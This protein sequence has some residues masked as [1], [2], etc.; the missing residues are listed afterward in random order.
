MSSVS[1][2][3]VSALPA[4]GRLMATLLA[5]QVCGSTG[6]SISLA[7]G[8]IVAA[9]LTGSNTWSGLPVSV[10]ALGA[11][12]AS[13]PLARAM[14]RF[15]RRP[16]LVVGYGLGVLGSGLGMLGVMTR[17]FPLLLVGMLLFGIGQTSN[18]L[19][20][21][22]AADVST[23]AQRGRAIGLI[24]WGSTLGS[25]VGP[26][27]LGPAAWSAGPLGLPVVGSPFLIGLAGFGLAALLVEALLRPDPLTVAAQLE[28]PAKADR[29][30]EPARPLRTI[31]RQPSVRLA[32]GAL[33]TSQLVMIGT[34]STSPVYLHD[35]GHHVD[36]IGLAVSLHLAG[37]YAASPL[38]GWLCDRFGRI[39][40]ITAGGLVLIGAVAL[41]A[42]APGSDSTVVSLALFLNGVGWNFGFVAG[43]ALLT[44]SL[45]PAERTSMQGLAD[46]VMGLMGAIGSAIGGVILQLW[47][48]PILNIVGAALILGPLTAIWPR[49]SG[50]RPAVGAE[51]APR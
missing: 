3:P 16:G 48:F 24:V 14:G 33:M 49:R 30:A 35:H 27:L 39:A 1:S 32:L 46:L 12:L 18:L 51:L 2:V 42:L 43:S 26:N 4:R 9:D 28:D 38:T 25:I 19:A 37:M 23:G 8:S 6:H 20:R 22:A 15:G 29:P 5:A 7:V 31:L 17:S 45:S 36:T 44:D 10:G 47:G 11:A 50:L 34:T 41:A 13:V 21:Y 40:V